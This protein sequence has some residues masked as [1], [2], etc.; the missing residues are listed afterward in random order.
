MKA[1]LPTLAVSDL[2][3]LAASFADDLDQHRARRDRDDRAKE[4]RFQ[5]PPAE[6][7]PDAAADPDDRQH[8]DD[9][10]ERGDLARAE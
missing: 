5:R 1:R 3:R 7:E 10:A 2:N 4:E 8:L 6:Q 9:R